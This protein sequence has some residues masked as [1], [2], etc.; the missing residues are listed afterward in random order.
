[1][2]DV[3]QDSTIVNTPSG[4]VTSSGT[5]VNYNI[6]AKNTIVSSRHKNGY[7]AYLVGP[8]VI[9]MQHGDGVYHSKVGSVTVSSEYSTDYRGTKPLRNQLS[10]QSNGW[11]TA[12]TV[13]TGW[14]QYDFVDGIDH[15][16]CGLYI[17]LRD[18]CPANSIKKWQL[19][20]WD[21]AT[22]TWD[23][24][25]KRDNDQP[26]RGYNNNDKWYGRM[27]WF[28]E[29]T[30][31]YKRIRINIDSNNGGSYAEIGV[32]RFYENPIPGMHK[33]DTAL[34]ASDKN[35]FTGS[36]AC[37]V[38][39]NGTSTI[40]KIISITKPVIYDGLKMAECSINSMY[41][42]PE[43]S[44]GVF[45]PNLNAEKA[46]VIPKQ[47]AS[48]TQFYL[49]SDHRTI[50]YGSK[51]ELEKECYALLR[52]RH[53]VD[54]N[55]V[56]ESYFEH[57][58]GAFNYELY[59]HNVRIHTSMPYRGAP[60]S[61]NFSGA[62]TN[63]ISP[64]KSIQTDTFP[65]RHCHTHSNV[66]TMEVDFKW[67]G[68]DPTAADNYYIIYDNG[69]YTN[70]G[71]SVG[72]HNRRKC[73]SLHM[74]T[75]STNG[76]MYTIPFNATDNKWHTLS[77]TMNYDKIYMH[78]DGKCLG[79]FEQCPYG[80]ANYRYWMLGRWIHSDGYQWYGYLNNLRVTLGTALYCADDYKV[81]DIFYTTLVPDK[82]LWF[83][84]A[85]HV[86]KEYQAATNT[87]INTPM[88][89]L[90]MVVTGRKE[91]LLTDQPRGTYGNNATKWVET[92]GWT[93]DGYNDGNSL[94]QYLFNFGNSRNYTYHTLNTN[95][96][97]H[98]IQFTLETP[99]TF[100]RFVLCA[101]EPS[102]WQRMLTK[103]KLVASNDNATWTTLIDNSTYPD[104]GSFF[105][106]SA[107]NGDYHTYDGYKYF[108]YDNATAFKY[109][110]IIVL[111]KAGLLYFQDVGYTC[112]NG[113]FT[114]RGAKPEVYDRKSVM[115]GSTWEL[116]PFPCTTN[117]LY[118]IPIPTWNLCIS[119]DG[120]VEESENKTPQ[121]RRPIMQSSG[122]Y[123]DGHSQHGE[124]V[125]YAPGW[126]YI[127]T[128]NAAISQYNGAA[129]SVL[130]NE[131]S[132]Y[133]NYYIICR[134]EA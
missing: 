69:W 129:W 130:E 95:N 19:L 85:E 108:K 120:Y 121:Q 107:P 70:A 33:Y 128:R 7:P 112:I 113:T 99:M 21:E 29:N 134:R 131:Q 98:W 103:F 76:W 117:N 124:I 34:Y 5:V 17:N 59:Y 82:T 27:H 101:S 41:I 56:A 97:D 84:P 66:C 63:F 93:T 80:K 39:D 13:T 61:Y 126:L 73:I 96:V 83:D 60:S 23:T 75:P 31:A 71:W 3:T 32:L 133:G 122:W 40:D 22:S 123:S 111:A 51:S 26:L 115:V 8:E 91:H 127:K 104:D 47:N 109:Y 42:V 106:A 87:W 78:V 38:N 50:H 125:S 132:N 68:P 105:V 116:G 43:N 30:K 2:G 57:N 24:I 52:S 74:G 18:N 36:V 44:D 88:L 48:E 25:Y 49:Y 14:W 54:Y 20:G 65:D 79:A 9:D 15:V 94:P 81:S 11:L 77:I 10:Y 62:A 89:P 86:V 35:P 118:V 12:N 110:K 37:G 72:Y 6:F 64:N 45:P 28:T 92:G 67:A 58:M 114:F 1:M 53:T 102:Y 100:E 4:N 90:G 55:P 16:L 46:V 119:V